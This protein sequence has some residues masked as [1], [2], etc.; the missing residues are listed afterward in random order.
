MK[1]TSVLK[2]EKRVQNLI[3]SEDS[4]FIFLEFTYGLNVLKPF[5]YFVNNICFHFYPFLKTLSHI[6][7][8]K[9]NWGHYWMKTETSWYRDQRMT[10][11]CY[12]YVKTMKL[13]SV[14]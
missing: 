4:L 2:I 14:L 12:H 5:E 7:G 11:L 6:E 13:L 9:K 3:A 1:F 10:N 8:L